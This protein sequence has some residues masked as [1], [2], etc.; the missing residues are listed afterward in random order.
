MSEA[1]PKPTQTIQE[2]AGLSGLRLMVAEYEKDAA[3]WPKEKRKVYLR[4]IVGTAEEL[5]VYYAQ[6]GSVRTLSA[7]VKKASST[8]WDEAHQI[9]EKFGATPP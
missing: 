7:V 3:S 1:A 9:W 6:A 8:K 5:C 2:D 4:V